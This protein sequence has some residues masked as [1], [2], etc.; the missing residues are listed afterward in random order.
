MI[1]I[2]K[3]F[4]KLTLLDFP[5][6]TACTVFTAGCNFRCGFC[7]NALLVTETDDT[8]VPENEFFDFLKTRVGILD[9]V[10][11]TGGEPLL[12]KGIKEF[13]RKIR[14]LGFMIKLD[15][16]GT[17]P[18]LLKEI[19]DEGLVDYVAV[20]IKNS[21]EK[22]AMTVGLNELD[23]TPIKKTVDILV[24]GSVDY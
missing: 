24:N 12:Q 6:R 15:H 19:I 2:I 16:N 3:G 21:P 18:E 1:M 14:A 23:I 5:G 17:K 9:G 13:M 4:Q 22:Y 10:A 11:I 7:H 8:F 20:D